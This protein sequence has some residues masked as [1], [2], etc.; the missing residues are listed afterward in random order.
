MLIALT[1]LSVNASRE[2]DAGKL[3]KMA[4][5]QG[6]LTDLPPTLPVMPV[7]SDPKMGDG[8]VFD[9]ASN[10]MIDQGHL[11]DPG[12]AQHP[13]AGGHDVGGA[14]GSAGLTDILSGFWNS[15]FTDPTKWGPYGNPT[16][17]ATPSPTPGGG[18]SGGG[19]GGGGAG[20]P[21]GAGGGGGKT[22]T[23][24]ELKH[25]CAELGVESNQKAAGSGDDTSDTHSKSDTVITLLCILGTLFLALVL[26][27]VAFKYFYTRISTREYTSLRLK[28][29]LDSA[30]REV[31][32]LAFVLL[33]GYMMLWSGATKEIEKH[34]LG[35][36]EG[37]DHLLTTLYGDVHFLL[38]SAMLVFMFLT[39]ILVCMAENTCKTWA[40]YEACAKQPE[41]TLL[42]FAKGNKKIGCCGGRTK[43]EQEA[44]DFLTFR[45]QFSPFLRKKADSVGLVGTRNCDET[46]ARFAHF[47][48][49]DYLSITLANKLASMLSISFSSWILIEAFMLLLALP[50]MYSWKVQL[51][52][53]GVFPY[54]VLVLHLLVRCNLKS[55]WYAL[56][57]ESPI[58]EALREEEIPEEA[59]LKTLST[60][61]A[62]LMNIVE[63]KSMRPPKRLAPD[64]CSG[65]LDEDQIPWVRCWRK[66]EAGHTLFWFGNQG[67]KVLQW[68]IRLVVVLSAISAILVVVAS[69]IAYSELGYAG[70]A[71]AL[72]VGLFPLMII[73]WQI[74]DVVM[75]VAVL[76]SVGAFKKP[77]II[78][79]VIDQSRARFANSAMC[80]L[81]WLVVAATIKALKAGDEEAKV[82]KINK[83][84]M[85][86]FFDLLSEGGRV[87]RSIFEVWYKRTKVLSAK[88]KL[89]SKAI[90]VLY[91]LADKDQKGLDEQQFTQLIALRDQL[92]CEILYNL[93][94]GGGSYVGA[95]ERVRRVIDEK[96][97]ITLMAFIE[98]INTV[99]ESQVQIEHELIPL[100]KAS[101]CRKSKD[102]QTISYRDIPVREREVKVYDLVQIMLKYAPTTRRSS[103]PASQQEAV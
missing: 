50:L 39:F 26:A 90:S 42:D 72:A 35:Y 21:A 20:G 65:K 88:S 25:R 83:R 81:D 77:R 101:R 23:L 70:L 74:Q 1:L 12:G 40:Y 22:E 73:L 8:D 30:A 41:W 45:I 62:Q 64:A 60:K 27:D 47:D 82:D 55:I 98:K 78:Q 31:T 15:G 2:S 44:M 94:G 61:A 95:M 93:A 7:P 75:H 49:A 29:V 13:G 48:F 37:E 24:A 100:F 17:T 84:V 57:N 4:F 99:T 54:L 16:P 66:T 85:K 46:T 102:N 91:K 14:A 19:G 33:C 9:Y 71:S 10:T 51:I 53:F 86:G 89:S 92:E 80:M 34:W 103:P 63:N 68:S 5:R 96:H 76:T 69:R 67:G 28:V 52:C 3:F 18:S 6:A 79:A 32:V 97:D 43:D 38:T 87:K 59:D 58:Q 56:T 11:S 36:G